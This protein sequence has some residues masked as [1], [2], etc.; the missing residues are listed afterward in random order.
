MGCQSTLIEARRLL[1]FTCN[2][3]CTQWEHKCAERKTEINL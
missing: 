3:F 1:K 2:T